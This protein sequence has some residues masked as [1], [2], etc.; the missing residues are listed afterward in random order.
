M[1][2]VVIN[3]GGDLWK[4]FKF[5]YEEFVSFISCEFEVANIDATILSEAYVEWF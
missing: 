2:I 4:N 3:G 1:V 5:K